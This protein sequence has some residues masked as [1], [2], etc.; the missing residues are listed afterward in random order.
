[1]KA[2]YNFKKGIASFQKHRNNF[3]LRELINIAKKKRKAPQ[4]KMIIV[5]GIQ[6]GIV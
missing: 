1:M 4:N 3:F 2:L 6:N 5:F